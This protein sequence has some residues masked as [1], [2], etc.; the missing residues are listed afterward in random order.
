MSW[1][2]FGNKL[3]ALNS[4]EQALFTDTL[5]RLLAQSWLWRDDDDD[6]RHYNFLTRYEDLVRQYLSLG[7][8]E[9]HHAEALR[10]FHV[11]SAE[12]AHRRRL[13]KALTLWLLIARLIYQEQREQNRTTLNAWPLIKVSDLYDRYRSFFPGRPVR[14]K[15]EFTE[16]LRELRALRLIRTPE[17]GAPRADTPDKLIE[18]LPALEIVISAGTLAELAALIQQYQGEPAEDQAGEAD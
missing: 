15:G 7:G 5:R 9:L 14:V 18:L 4:S 10:L 12:N 6:R 8:W 16:A 11:R 13:N 2:D 3:D 17:G 1:T